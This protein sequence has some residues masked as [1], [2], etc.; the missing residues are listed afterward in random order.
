[1]I[2]VCSVVLFLLQTPCLVSQQS[3]L[4]SPSTDSD[5]D[6]LSDY[7]EQTLLQYFTPTFMTDQEECSTM[8]A[9]FAR[10]INIPKVG[11]QNGTIYGQVFPAKTSDLG[12]QLLE[13]HFYH[14]WR[15]DCGAHGH[16]L[17]AEHV[18]VLIRS[19]RVDGTA[20]AWKALYWY[21]AAHEDTVCDVSQI[22]RAVT[23]KAEDRGATVWISLGK[24]ASFLA[25]ELCHRGCGR[26]QC[27]QMSRLTVRQIV[28]LGEVGRPM[29]GS[30]WTSSAAW[31]LS[32][33]MTQSD[34]PAIA[35][36]RLETL[37]LTDI[38]WF[39]PGRHPAQGMI[40]ISDSTAE[41][42][43]TSSTDAFTAI[44]VA[45]DS[46]SNALG[47]S[48]RKTTHAIGAAARRVGSALRPTPKQK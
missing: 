45:N 32:G 44:S 33:K 40:A 23:L 15:Q 39:N 26:D 9:E 31:P 28:N 13:L 2:L 7:L 30:S 42:I 36:A 24:H 29:N 12:E 11:E 20:P 22:A 4:V 46:T 19:S 37:P 48:Y 21:A 6:G 41:A 17:D 3:P 25:P 38:A 1:M 16:P 10:D 14:L 43:G 27:G 34:F 47:K 8:P 35:L 5:L 18:S